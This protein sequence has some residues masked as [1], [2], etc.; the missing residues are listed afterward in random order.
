MRDRAGWWRGW[1]AEAAGVLV[2]TG[3]AGCGADAEEARLRYGVCASCR[4]HLEPAPL[5][6]EGRG[7]G[8]PVLAALEYQGVVAGVLGAVKERGRTDAL[9]ALAP[10]LAASVG[11]ALTGLPSRPGLL[12]VAVPSSPRAVRRRGFRPVDELLRR[13]G[14]PVS[15][16]SRLVLARSVRDQAG[17]SSSERGTNLHGALRANGP[18]EGRPVLLVDDVVT[19]GATLAEAARAVRAAGSEVVAAAC[20]AHTPRRHTGGPATHR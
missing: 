11:L 4:P 19:T 7:L 3:C 20:L 6:A 9:A 14:H 18:F 8:F 1:L 10:A 13:A 15:R 5:E 17:L 12:L 16:S 2:P